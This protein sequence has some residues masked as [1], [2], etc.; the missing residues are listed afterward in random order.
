MSADVWIV[1]GLGTLV[2]VWLGIWT[3]D[4]G[5]PTLA[6]P[7]AEPE[8]A[9]AE[10]R[11]PQTRPVT[12]PGIALTPRD[13]GFFG[14]WHEGQMQGCRVAVQAWDKG[15]TLFAGDF[16]PNCEQ[17]TETYLAQASDANPLPEEGSPRRLAS[18]VGAE[19]LALDGRFFLNALGCNALAVPAVRSALGQLSESVEEVGLLESGGVEMLLEANVDP[20]LLVADLAVA[21]SLHRAL[22][23]G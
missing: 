15:V 5:G 3:R 8:T 11:A 2:F 6:E 4:E 18:A 17:I 22:R 23:S 14:R 7:P 16:D 13:T 1:V 12:L 20:E 9:P 19:A 21:I 10:T